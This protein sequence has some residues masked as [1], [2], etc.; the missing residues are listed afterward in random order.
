MKIKPKSIII[1]LI[2][3]AIVAFAVV[4]FFSSSAV[5]NDDGRYQYLSSIDYSVTL[6]DDGSADIV[7]TWNIFAKHTN[8]LF[9]SFN[10][11]DRYGTIINVSVKDLDRNVVMKNY[12]KW[13]YYAP[14]DYFYAAK[15][16]SSSDFEIGWGVGMEDTSGW[17]RFEVSYTVTDAMTAYNDCQE[18]YWQFLAK[19]QNAVP[20]DKVT[21]SV[22]LPR[23]VSNIENLKIWAHGAVNG[24]IHR[25]DKKTVKFEIDKLSPGAMVEVRTVTTEKV[26]NNI[27]SAKTRNYNYLNNIIKEEK[28]WSLETNIGIEFG[29]YVLI[30]FA[31]VEVL[32]IAINIVRIAKLKR[33]S[34]EKGIE[35]HDIKYFREI[36]RE[37]D[38][39]PAEALYL[40]KFNKTRLDTGDVQQKAVASIILD[41]CLKKK[42]SL[43]TTENT[44]MVKIIADQDGL[45]EDELEVYKLL[46]KAGSSTEEFDIE[47]LNKYAK[48]KYDQ[49]SVSINKVVNECRN[50]LYKLKL[51]DKAR[52]KNYL[53]GESAGYKFA[54]LKYSYIGLC[55]AHLYAL[56]IPFFRRPLV[57]GMGYG[58]SSNLTYFLIALIPLVITKLYLWN[59]QKQILKNISVLTQAG[60]DEKEEWLALKKYLTDYS[61]IKDKEVPDLVLWERYLVYATAFGISDKVIENLKATYP[62]VFVKESWDD[63]EMSQYPI[64]NFVCNPYYIYHD[65]S[66]SSRI[67]NI[68]SSVSKA[69]HTSVTEI[70]RH[71]SSGGGSG[72]RRRLLWRRRTAVEAGG[73]HGR[74]IKEENIL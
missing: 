20:A 16:Y 39:T 18:F 25:V 45:K 70:A 66:Y 6:N 24:E 26:A 43:R 23:E 59:K 47:D 61:L 57:Y 4:F 50:S 15:Q 38:S 7:E 68:G 72:R 19:G 62:E 73:R 42:I 1:K 54:M 40:S 2:V 56:F 48:K 69:Y 30:I 35:K 60:S 46:K 53:K 64:I 12:G 11:S 33:L 63:Q 27:S 9:K 5:D 37:N 28:E 13:V 52:E 29:R 22:T 8:T 3:T 51:I 58:L 44:T 65:V 36:P 10:E 21:G 31:I 32:I 49:Y 74:K 55:I 67:S 17:R 41:L 71:A 14:T 34:E